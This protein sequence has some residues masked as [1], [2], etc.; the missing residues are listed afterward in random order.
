MNRYKTGN[1]AEFTILELAS[2]GG[3]DFRGV[4]KCVTDFIGQLRVNICIRAE[5]E[6][7]GCQ[8]CGGGI[9]ATND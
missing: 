8:N 6:D 4:G 5:K 9:R 1:R 2:S 7:N 3:S